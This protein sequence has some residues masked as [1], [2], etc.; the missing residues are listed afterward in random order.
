MWYLDTDKLLYVAVIT[1]DFTDYVDGEIF[2][3]NIH[4]EEGEILD[5]HLEN[6]ENQLHQEVVNLG[7][8]FFLIANAG[9][10]RT[11]IIGLQADKLIQDPILLMLSAA[12]LEIISLLYDHDSLVLYKFAKAQVAIRHSTEVLSFSTLDEFEIY[13]KNEFSYYLDDGPRP[14]FITMG[15]G[16]DRELRI[17]VLQKYDIHA[18]PYIESSGWIEVA[19][20]YQTLSCP[21]YTPID[22]HQN[23]ISFF[24]EL[25]PIAF[26]VTAIREA[27]NPEVIM[28]PLTMVFLLI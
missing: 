24:V 1:D 17:E 18:V 21:I 19:N 7:E 9:I 8:I 3:E 26:W 12:E 20:V 22:F 14:R 28:M 5:K 23:L 15:V 10:G 16:G 6:V 2:A 27:E 25:S 4:V 11:R 13:R